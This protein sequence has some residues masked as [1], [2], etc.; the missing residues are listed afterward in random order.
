MRNVY[1]HFRSELE[2]DH[3]VFDYV[4]LDHTVFDYII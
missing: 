1:T 3:A 4:K 2:L